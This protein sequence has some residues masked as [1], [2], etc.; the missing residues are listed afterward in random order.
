LPGKKFSP[1]RNGYERGAAE[2]KT[3][4]KKEN[5]WATTLHKGCIPCNVII[6]II[7]L[8]TTANIIIIVLMTMGQH[9]ELGLSSL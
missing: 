5:Q 8:T 4:A 9:Q 1:G 3:E 2:R 7:I 6:I